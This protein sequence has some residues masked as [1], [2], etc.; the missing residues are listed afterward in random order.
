M[1]LP[2]NPT[3]SLIDATPLWLT[4]GIFHNL[5]SP[6][7][8]SLNIDVDVLETDYYLA[9]SGKKPI[10]PLV[11]NFLDEDAHITNAGIAMLGKIIM[12]K[13]YEPWTHLLATYHITYSPI[14]N[15]NITEHHAYEESGDHSSSD[16]TTYG[17]TVTTDDDSET[18]ETVSDTEDITKQEVSTQRDD[19]DRYGYNSTTGVP[20]DRYNTVLNRNNDD[21]KESSSSRTGSANRD[22]SVVSSGKDTVSGSKEDSTEGTRDIT[23]SGLNG[24]VPIQKLIDDDRKL[25]LTNFFDQVYHDIDSVMTLPIYPSKR[26]LQ[27]WVLYAGRNA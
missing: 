20:T 2:D 12:A 7:W 25:W 22:I 16:E 27:P 21:S 19:A 26:R 6:P 15:Y 10:A 11:H 4:K 23:R 8:D 9:N 24:I 13:F 3:I 14:V 17:K 5:V 18:D 1:V